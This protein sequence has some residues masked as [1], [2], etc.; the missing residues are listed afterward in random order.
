MEVKAKGTMI[1]YKAYK[2]L[3]RLI[4]N[5]GFRKD[6]IAKKIGVHPSYLSHYCKGRRI[7]QQKVLN[8]LIKVLGC[9]IEDI[10]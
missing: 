7:P 2:R 4:K 10:V 5:T 8:R 6:F 3:N 9:Q 1:K